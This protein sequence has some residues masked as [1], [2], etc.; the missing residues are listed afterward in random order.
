MTDTKI[1]PLLPVPGRPIMIVVMML[2]HLIALLALFSYFFSWTGVCLAIAGAVLSSLGINL[3]YH[4][5][6]AHKGLSCSKRV[7]HC[8]AVLGVMAYQ[9]GPAYWVA[10]HRRHHQFADEHRDPHSPATGFFWSHI[11]W[12]FTATANTDPQPIMERYAK[13]V[14]KDPFYA[15]LEVNGNWGR[16]VGASGAVYFAVGALAEMLAGGTIAGAVQFGAS[17]FVWG[18]VVRTVFVWHVTFSIN[19]VCHCWGYRNH[20]T[21]DRSRNNLV[22]GILAFGEGWHNNH[23]ASPR[24][25][26][27]GH[28]WWELDL[29]WLVIKCLA[30]VGLVT[31]LNADEP[32]RS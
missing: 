8:L 2:Y 16:I 9:F 12:L 18:A 23:H 19:S 14:L 30:A 32:R 27:H 3:C 24:S 26:R 22:F 20:A 10:I 15:W 1:D 11:G 5:M 21:P 17:L 7:E 13:D 6:L 31:I 28:R 29:T 25:A 4:R